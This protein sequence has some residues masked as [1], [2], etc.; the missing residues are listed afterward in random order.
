M[1]THLV[2]PD[3]HAHFEH[4]NDR[5]LW[6][7]KLINDIRPDVVINL[8]DCWDMPSLGGFEKGKSAVGRT[9]R[10]DVDA[11][12]DWNDKLWSTVKATKKRLPHRVFLEGNHEYRIHRA[13]DQQPHLDGAISHGDLRIPDW[14][15]E[16]VPYTGGTPG[17]IQLDGVHYA[18]YFVSG[19]MGRSVSG[20]HAGYS[21]LTKKFVSCT[22]GHTHTF[23]FAQRT[24]E[25]GRKINGLV[26]GSCFDY[27]SGW[28][29]ECQKLYWQ[30]VIIKK[31]VEDGVYDL[32]TV[33]LD[34][35][36]KEYGD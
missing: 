8:G 1:S 31:N 12:L 33:S 32:Q 21:L 6:I 20:E 30:G 16:W 7:G 36:R 4:N 35:L 17:T 3:P 34:S 11:G 27:Q 10:A 5:A 14:Y 24:R 9:Y 18:H 22:Q 23:D 29:G 25:D 2:I 28:A 26:A 15:D 19:V 13:I